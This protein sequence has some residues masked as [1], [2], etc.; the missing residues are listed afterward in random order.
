VR[1]LYTVDGSTLLRCI[2]DG[3]QLRS[4]TAANSGGSGTHT[5]TDYVFLRKGTHTLSFEA[6]GSASTV[7]G[8]SA[9]LALSTVVTTP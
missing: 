2:V 6:L 4:R 9:G 7:R 8:V 1:Y 5:G 3:Q